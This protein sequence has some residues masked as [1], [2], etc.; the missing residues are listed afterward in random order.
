[1]QTGR[2]C[3]ASIA[4]MTVPILILAAGASRR[5]NGRDKLLMDVG[6]DCLL[7]HV[8]SR[9]VATGHPV[10][11]TL[12][13]GDLAR[14]NALAGLDV[15]IISV[16]DADQGMGRSLSAGLRAVSFEQ[17]GLLVALADMPNITTDDYISIIN[18]FESNPNAN[19][20]RAAHHDGTKGN[21]VLLPKWALQELGTL[22]EDAGAR[23]LLRQY[24]DKVCLVPL[25]DDHATTDLD[26][27]EDWAAWHAQRKKP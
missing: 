26:T 5:M 21:P 15:Q 2:G 27:P 13:V 22:N 4:C 14:R 6:G 19:I 10:L 20:H 7:H 12:P 25:P 8:V 3:A 1:M 16:K 17:A 18:N 23:H 9:A 24:A 11:V